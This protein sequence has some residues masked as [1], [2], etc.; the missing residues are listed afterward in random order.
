MRLLVLQQRAG[1][2]S[3]P[4]DFLDIRKNTK[5]LRKLA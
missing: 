4:K 3:G 1:G 2:S 5:C